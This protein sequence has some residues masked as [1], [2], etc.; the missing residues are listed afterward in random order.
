MPP[1]SRPQAHVDL[2]AIVALHRIL[3]DVRAAA[4]IDLTVQ[5][6]CLQQE[7]SRWSL[8]SSDPTGT[9]KPLPG[10]PRH[11]MGERALPSHRLTSSAVESL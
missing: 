10:V 2:E 5:L 3:G 6:I 1:P 4:Q 7:G 9:P 8:D 11:L